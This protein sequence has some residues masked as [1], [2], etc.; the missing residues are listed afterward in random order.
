MY[1]ANI[2]ELDLDFRKFEIANG[3]RMTTWLACRR[4]EG[5]FAGVCAVMA[6]NG[7]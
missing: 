6:N 1:A 3:R 7:K 4:L 2:V 5:D